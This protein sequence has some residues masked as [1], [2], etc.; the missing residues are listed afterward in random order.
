MRITTS[1]ENLNTAIN[2]VQRA[3]NPKS[4][5]PLYLCI[6]LEVKGNTAIFTGIGL[7]ISIECSIPVQTEKEGCALIPSRYFG[8]IVRR[9]PD[10]PITLEHTDSMELSIRYDQSIFT[11]KTLPADDFPPIAAFSEGQSFSVPAETIIWMI[12]KSSFAASTDETKAIFTGL[13]WEINGEELSLVGTDTHRLAWAKG[14]AQVDNQ[15]ISTSFIIPAK[16]AIE[17]SRLI[18]NDDCHVLFEKNTVLFSF[19]NIRISCQVM[20]GIF[21][22]YQQVIPDRFI[23]SLY[24]DNKTLRDATERISLFSSS[25]DTSSSIHLEIT[26][27]TLSLYSQSDIGFGREDFLVEHEGENLTI[28]FNSRYITDV[29]KVIDGDRISFELTGQ[30]SAGIMKEKDQNDFLYLLLPVKT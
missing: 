14:L 29:F 24:V 3:I 10:I 26:D 6:K 19:E 16:T 23:T 30:L 28:S 13:L 25:G 15:E 9:L 11:L 12:R 1:K 2:A 7:D 21:P 27:G 18:Q 20:K 8:D 17:I 5:I 22:N 4:I